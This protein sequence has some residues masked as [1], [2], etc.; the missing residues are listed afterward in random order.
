M[1]D[2]LKIMVEN[3]KE[4]E[5]IWKESGSG[6]EAYGRSAESIPGFADQV[7]YTQYLPYIEAMLAIR[8]KDMEQVATLEQELARVTLM[9]EEVSRDRDRLLSMVPNPHKIKIGKWNVTKSGKYYRGF[10]KLGDKMF[11]VYLGPE[12]D[13]GEAWE[14]IKAREEREDFR[15]ALAKS[16]QTS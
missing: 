2:P 1:A 15:E 10:R 4:I 8:E 11:A 6:R 7:P 14:R 3:W 12:F 5:G 9:L 13:E 16:R